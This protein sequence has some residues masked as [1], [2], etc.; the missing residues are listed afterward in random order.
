VWDS[1]AGPDAPF[2][3][4]SCPAAIVPTPRVV[5]PARSSESLAIDWDQDRCTFEPSA[6]MILPNPECPQT[7]VPAGVYS[8]TVNGIYQASGTVSVTILG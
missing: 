8:I 3:A 6:P 2:D 5:Y 7:P 4:Y 1:G